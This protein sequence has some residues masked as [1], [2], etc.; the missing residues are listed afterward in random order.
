MVV[1]LGGVILVKQFR[2]LNAP[3]VLPLAVVSAVVSSLKITSPSTFVAIMRLGVGLVP[4]SQTRKPYTV[5]HY[6][7]L[8]LKG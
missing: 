7:I 5:F 8:A 2:H 4:R 6:T 1:P 3:E